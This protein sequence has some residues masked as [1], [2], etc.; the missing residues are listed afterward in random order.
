MQLE[1][2][3]AIRNRR[4]RPQNRTSDT[5][6]RPGGKTAFDKR[7]L[8]GQ[9]LSDFVPIG[10]ESHQILAPGPFHSIGY[11]VG[12][13]WAHSSGKN[14]LVGI[15]RSETYIFDRHWRFIRFY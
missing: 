5:L 6:F 15:G 1:G 12:N 10:H 14:P 11:G 3:G 9:R 8:L 7:A 2:G 13:S 4:A